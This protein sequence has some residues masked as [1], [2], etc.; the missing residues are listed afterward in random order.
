MRPRTAAAAAVIALA[1]AGAVAGGVAGGGTLEERWISDT[2]RD[3][4][5]NHH[6]V[7]AAD[8]VIVA[9]VGEPGG[10]D[11]GPSSC[12]LVRL[13][14][15]TGSVEWRYGVPPANCSLHSLTE[16]AI[17]DLDGDGSREVVA[18]STERALFALDGET[19][20][21]RWRVDLSSFGYGR[22]TVADATGDG[23]REAVVVA[24]D[25]QVTAVRS[26]GTVLWR[27]A[28]GEGAYHAPAVGDVTGDGRPEVVVGTSDRTVALDGETGTVRWSAPV[29]GAAFALGNADGDAAPEVVA[30]DRGAVRALD[31]ADG[32]VLWRRN[33]S[34]TPTLRTVTDAD[35][36][37]RA[38]AYVGYSGNRVAALDA[39]TGDVEWTTRLSESRRNAPGPV[40]GD[41]TGDG[42]PDLAVA[43]SDGTVS[44]LDPATGERRASYARETPIL[45]HLALADL[46]GDGSREILVRYGDGRVVALAYRD[47]LL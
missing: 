13:D 16:P 42:T 15:E 45:T 38:E 34:G 32:T 7:G 41:V 35:G 1:L 30:T 23:S 39:Q 2:A 9:P 28:L 27:R 46:D 24:I 17:A 12:A 47:G 21:E 20:E 37:G 40:V 8:G 4:E 14:P 5:V 29:G 10:S 26:D 36:D 18:A 25:G 33:L 19:G 31:G 11:V 43:A 3:N 6:A 44:V 22:P